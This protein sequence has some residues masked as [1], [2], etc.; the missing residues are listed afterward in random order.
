MVG[1]Q[2]EGEDRKIVTVG[3][4]TGLGLD[5]KCLSMSGTLTQEEGSEPL[6]EEQIKTMLTDRGREKL[7]EV[8]TGRVSRSKILTQSNL[9]YRKD[10]DLGD[11][12]TV[13]NRQWGLTMNT[14]IT[15]VAEVYEPS[16]VRTDVT[17]QQY[18][19]TID[20]IGRKLRSDEVGRNLCRFFDSTDTDE[21]LYSADEFAE[22][23][24]QVLADGVFNGGTNLKVESTGKN[25][26]TYIQPGYAWLQGYLYAVKDTKLNLLHPFIHMLRWIV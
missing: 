5:M 25:M 17:L 22:Y 10:Y 15:E 24:R 7:A 9:T 4:S 8:K 18:S 3:T 14:R 1:G 20:V 26:E 19:D 16:Q 6:S 23:F 11:V 21:R 2:G 12:V 13:L